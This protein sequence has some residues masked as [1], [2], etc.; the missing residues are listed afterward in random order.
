MTNTNALTGSVIRYLNLKGYNCWRSNNISAPGRRFTGLR[1][2]PDVIGYHKKTG[3]FIGVEVKNKNDKLSLEQIEFGINALEGGA[4]WFLTYNIENLISQIDEKSY[5][6]FYIQCQ[7]K[8]LRFKRNEMLIH[9]PK[10]RK[11]S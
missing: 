5:N 10:R 1:G 2:L 4:M 8:G 6:E 7:L 11:K 9:K 3:R